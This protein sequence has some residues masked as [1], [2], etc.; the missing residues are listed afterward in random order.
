MSSSAGAWFPVAAN[1]D[2][3]GWD[4][5]VELQSLVEPPHSRPSKQARP[6]KR[7]RSKCGCL[8]DI[9][10][11]R[12]L[13]S[14][15][16]NVDELFEWPTEIVN[17]IARRQDMMERMVRLFSC[18]MRTSSD[19]AGMDCP[20]EALEQL[21]SAMKKQWGEEPGALM[22]MYACDRGDLPQTVLRALREKRG[23]GCIFKRIQDRLPAD[24]RDKCDRMVPKKELVLGEKP[25]LE[26]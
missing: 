25:S 15:P 21:I 8:A 22:H 7:L 2:D 14:G 6:S 12:T 11:H 13:P 23:H 26:N 24:M 19:Y 3:T 1:D 10:E 9:A 18:G 17:S 4:D 16:S 5:E 20:G